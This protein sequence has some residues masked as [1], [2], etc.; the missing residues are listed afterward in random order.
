MN[1]GIKVYY[2]FLKWKEDN[3]NETFSD[4]REGNHWGSRAILWNY[5]LVLNLSPQHSDSDNYFSK[6]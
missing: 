3:D 5:N 6:I 1:K 2:T 4:Y